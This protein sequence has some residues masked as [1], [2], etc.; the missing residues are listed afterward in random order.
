MTDLITEICSI[1][2]EQ[3]ESR[4]LLPGSQI[5][6]WIEQAEDRLTHLKQINPAAESEEYFEAD[7]IISN[8]DEIQEMRADIIWDLA[9]YGSGDVSLMTD[10]E[11]AIYKTLSEKACELRGE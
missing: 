4:H 5:T 11:S 9:F 1:R 3:K 6:K 2:L 10:R 8:L 7:C